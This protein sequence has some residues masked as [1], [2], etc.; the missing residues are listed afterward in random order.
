MLESGSIV[1]GTVQSRVSLLAHRAPS[2]S[3]A[4]RQLMYSTMSQLW[5]AKPQARTTVGASL[6]LPY[7]QEAQSK[8]PQGYKLHPITFEKDVDSNHHMDLIAGFA[9]MR[10][11]NYRIQ[12]VDKLKAKLIAGKIIPAI[13]TTTAMATGG[14]WGASYLLKVKSNV[15]NIILALKDHSSHC[16]G[17]GHGHR[18]VRGASLG[19]ASRSYR[20]SCG[21]KWF[22]RGSYPA[23]T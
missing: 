23:K 18:W 1:E 2:P 17:H 12:E 21:H 10:A 13:A 20:Y 15:V 16:N 22:L 7:L 4:V 11:R 8:L 6:S 19:Q 9:N 3:R 5:V 14:C